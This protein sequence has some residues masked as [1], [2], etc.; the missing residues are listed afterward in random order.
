MIPKHKVR[1]GQVLHIILMGALLQHINSNYCSSEALGIYN[2]KF[3]SA[4]ANQGLK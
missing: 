4:Q 3:L 1:S 2:D